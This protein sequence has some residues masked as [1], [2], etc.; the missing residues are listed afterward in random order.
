MVNEVTPQNTPP[1]ENTLFK[2]DKAL[3]GNST[4]HDNL[5]QDIII[6]TVDKAKLSLLKYE[7]ILKS[8]HDWAIYLGLFVTSLGALFTSDFRTLLGL[9]PE[10]WFALFLILTIASFIGFVVHGF[11]AIRNRHKVDITSVYPRY[12]QIAK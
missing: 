1:T 4:I 9:K 8:S 10:Y 5:G 11:R 6:T 2:I 7:A 12:V 3:L